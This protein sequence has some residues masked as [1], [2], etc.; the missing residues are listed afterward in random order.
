MKISLSWLADYIDITP[1]QKNLPEVL[2]KLTMRGLEVESIEDRSKGFDKVVVALIEERAQHPNADR[3][4]VCK[5][6][7]GT[8]VLQIVCGAKNMKAGDKVALSMI[9][10]NLPNGVK[11]EKGKIRDVESFGMLCSE[12]EL[13]LAEESEG[14]MI[15]SKDAPVGK[16]LA[17]FLGLDDIVFEI[18]VTPNRGDALSFIGIAR[19]LASITGQNLKLPVV[20]KLNE[21]GS[22]K[23]SDKV[24]LSLENPSSNPDLCIQY[25]GRY[26]EGVKI[27]PSP[28]WMQKKLKSIG[29][30]PINNVVDITNFVLMEWGTP[31]HAFDYA[32][33][34]NGTIKVRLA[35][36]G[37]KIPLLD[38][39]I[40]DLNESDLVIA[41]SE[42]PIALA[43]VMGGGNS[44]VTDS[45]KD[46]LLESAQFLSETVRRSSKKHQ[47]HTD[48]S[49]RFERQID[50]KAV[51]LASDRA[52][53]LIQE[54]AGGKIC[55]GVVSA[56]SPK[57][58]KLSMEKSITISSN[59]CSKFLGTK[60]SAET[61]S[62]ALNDVG[63]KSKAAADNVSVS[64]PTF[65]P[66]VE[67]K[68]DVYEEFIR[69]YGYD[70]IETVVP[71]MHF[72]PDPANVVDVKSQIV[73]SLKEAFMNE[74][75]SEVMNYAFVPKNQNAAWGGENASK[76]IELA[77]PLNEDF[78]TMKTS[79]IGSLIENYKYSVNHQIAE[80]RIFEIRPT[81][82]KDESMDTGVREITK[83]AGLMSGR[84]YVNAMQS[85]DR[86]LDFYDLKGVV[87]RVLEEINCRGL[88]FEIL[89]QTDA[90][91][92]PGQS[93][94]VVLGRGPC[95]FIGRLHP[96]RENE[97]KFRNPVY[98]F[99]VE[100]DRVLE[101][102]KLEKKY[103]AISKF[104]KVP[105][106]L[107]LIVPQECSADKVT[108]TMQ[109]HGKPLIENI[110]VVDL[111]RGD[112]IPKGTYSLSVTFNL[113]DPN[114]T[115]TDS[116][117]DLS[118]QKVLQGL[119]KDVSVQLR[120]Q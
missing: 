80:S 16:P 84:A 8:E 75:F 100:L 12:V 101:M 25:H 78:S 118:I 114:R 36:K 116:E 112:K 4:S 37:E 96:K 17:P 11:I 20:T 73:L 117:I 22:C 88:R 1:L 85:M 81:Y 76:S 13:G 65:R 31:L 113:S 15:L 56:L 18:N 105:R 107:S 82:I 40:I 48:S 46:L 91:L 43:G 115:L 33:I 23:T 44:E 67:I 79:L 39:T 51:R 30:R 110:Q 10:A 57:A 64:I 34:K 93:A 24:K 120:T 90:R 47:K 108:L 9:G 89:K 71:K 54:L 58:N 109:K 52:A 104:P 111:Y 2:E 38:Q 55:S 60:V 119:Q 97:L 29:L 6:N 19:E 102:V 99:E 32:K 70:K 63:F 7:N 62:K 14:I 69:S 50:Y 83:V 27:G 35:K 59:E 103:Q 72:I 41:D 49:H 106:D 68:Q 45:T 5:V 74:G 92:H 98:I 61:I 66:D 28:E 42:K 77:N 86:N 21:N 53:S 26:I 94:A 95:G 87:E 3:L